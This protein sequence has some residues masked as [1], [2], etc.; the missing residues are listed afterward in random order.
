MEI[1]KKILSYIGTAIAT[2]FLFMTGL[3][4]I[5]YKKNEK[6]EKDN[7]EKIKEETKNELEKKSADDIAADSP[8]P[9]TISANIEQEQQEL[10]ER[11]RNRLNKNLQRNGSRTDN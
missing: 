9:D 3:W 8:N 6:K 2:V 11:I 1:L 7:A 5:Q 10:R 4:I